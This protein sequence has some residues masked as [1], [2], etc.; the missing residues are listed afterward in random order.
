MTNEQDLDLD[1]ITA[2]NAN[3]SASQRAK[4][5]ESGSSQG[6]L[7]L[8]RLQEKNN[9]VITYE[10]VSFKLYKLGSESL[11]MVSSRI[12][13]SPFTLEKKILI[14]MFDEMSMKVM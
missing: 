2:S 1:D 3:R 12:T 11:V 9:Q 8:N 10:W 6:E 7:T 13:L 14:E 5:N 4:T